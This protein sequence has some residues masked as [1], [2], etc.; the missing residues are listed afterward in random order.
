[1]ALCHLTAVL[2]EFDD[3]ALW[4]NIYTTL[5]CIQLTIFASI[6]LED[7]QFMNH[8]YKQS[9]HVWYKSTS[10]WDKSTLVDRKVSNTALANSSSKSDAIMTEPR[11]QLL[12]LQPECH[13]GKILTHP[14]VAVTQ[15]CNISDEQLGVRPKEARHMMH[16]QQG[17]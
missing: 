12:L 4:S 10:S 16:R 15:L 9:H 7:V 8:S 11:L 17:P 6:C 5:I 13:C 3:R 1:M 2:S 14:V